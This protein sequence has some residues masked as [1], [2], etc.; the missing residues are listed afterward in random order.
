MYGPHISLLYASPNGLS[1]VRSFG[2]FFNAHKT[3]EDKLGLAGASYELVYAIPAV[4]EYLSPSDG[5]SKWDGIIRQETILQ[6]TL[7][8]YLNTRDDVTI[9]GETSPDARL[10]VPTI[11][12]TVRGW[13]SKELVE[14]VERQTNFGFRAGT[15]YS[16]RL[17]REILGFVGEGDAVVRV[18]MVHYNTG[19]FP[20]F[21]RGNL[22]G[23]ANQLRS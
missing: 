8:G 22:T 13:N 10:R 12:F 3:L 20:C 5:P 16:V 7:L 23:I 19:N 1:Q 2:H 18:S 14:T 4:T 17:A 15:F 9:W 11:S 21:L 6:E